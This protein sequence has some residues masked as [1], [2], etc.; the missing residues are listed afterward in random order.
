MNLESIAIKLYESLPSREE[1]S[2]DNI[3]MITDGAYYNYLIENESIGEY[4]NQ[5]DEIKMPEHLKKLC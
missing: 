1:C 5:H 2:G 4:F 3:Y